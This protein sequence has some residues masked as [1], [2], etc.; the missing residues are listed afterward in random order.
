MAFSPD[1]KRIVTGSEDKTVKVWDAETGQEVLALKGHTD[2]VSS[3][4]FSPDGKR[5]V[6]GSEDR[7]VKVWDAETG[8]EV[9][10]LKGH[11]DGVRGV[12]FSPDGKRIVTGSG[13]R[14]VK[15]WDAD[16]GPGTPHPQGAHRLGARAWRSAP[17]ASASSPA[18]GT[19]R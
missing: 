10:A 14:T 1:G 19:R 5:I 9:L 12:A 15:V 16:D 3:V 8:Q 17:T 7:T 11:T 18:A 4:A 6:T 13:D 2:D